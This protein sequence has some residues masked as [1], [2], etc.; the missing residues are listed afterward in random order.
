MFTKEEIDFLV[1]ALQYER[2]GVAN[3]LVQ[4]CFLGWGLRPE[5][6]LRVL[7]KPVVIERKTTS[8]ISRALDASMGN[9]TFDK[10]FELSHNVRIIFCLVAQTLRRQ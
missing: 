10:I 3:V 9:L 2:A 8:N 4:S 5:H 6:R 7:C 1:D